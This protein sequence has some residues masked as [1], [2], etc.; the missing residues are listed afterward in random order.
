MKNSFSIRRSIYYALTIIILF[1]WAGEPVSSQTISATIPVNDCYFKESESNMLLGNAKVE[2]QINRLSGTITGLMNKTTGVKYLGN[3]KPDIFRMEYSTFELHGATS[4]DIWSAGYGTLIYGNKQKVSASRFEKT[5]TGGKLEVSYDSLD[6]G[7]RTIAVSVS[8]TIELVN[9]NEETQWRIAIDNKDLG[10]IREVRFPIASGL[11]EFS[12]LIMPNQGG[13]KLTNP[14]KK[15]SDETPT[16]Y[17]EYPARAS[18]QWFEYFSPEAGLYMASYDKSLDYT[19]MYFG[20]QDENHDAAMWLVKYPFVAGGAKWESSHLAVG[21]HTGDWH[22]G[23]DRY[24]DWIESWVPKPEPV[25]RIAEMI[26]DGVGLFIKD[27]DMKTLNTYEDIVKRSQQIGRGSSIMLVGWFYN[28]HDT[29]YPEYNSI[30][31]LGGDKA[32]TDAIDKVHGMGNFVNAYVNGRLNNTETETYKKY[33]KKWAILG[34]TPGLGVGSINFFELHEGWNNAWDLAQKSEGWFSVM[35]PSAKGW[36]DHIVGQVIHCLRDYHFDG[37]FLDQPGSYYAELCYNKN[38]GHS[39]PASAWG[40]GLLEIFRRIHEEGKKINPEFAIWTEGMNDVYGQYLDYHTDKNP[41]WAPM[42]IHPEVE[43][44]VEMWRYT[45]PWYITQNGPERYSYPPSKDRVYGDY[46]H[47]LLGIRGISAGNRNWGG[48]STD[49]LAHVAVVDKIEKLWRKGGEFFFYGRFID[50]VG[51]NF[52]DPNI[53]AKAYISGNSAAIQLWNT[54]GKPVAFELNADLN[55]IFKSD[56]KIKRI[57]SL[58]DNKRMPFKS[59][60]NIVNIKV[61]LPPHE[62]AVFR[63]DTNPLVSRTILP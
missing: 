6:L 38:H 14:L 8:Y 57:A 23:A 63:I 27:M 54:T 46:Y 28:G 22:W 4:K 52:T 35:C 7:R 47:F 34:M 25:K 43:T 51:L 11:T 24:R 3:G 42:R 20:R 18:M 55:A 10:T 50:N 56:A 44:F 1:Q 58:E 9:N 31:D 21:I 45:L 53:L 16:I 13:E 59:A 33:G 32:L 19:R 36:Q 17:I 30:P 12:S 41:V 15:L 40:P 49:S 39:T 60:G 2:I 61:Q 37:I 5:P 26:G 48:N 29:Y 62:I